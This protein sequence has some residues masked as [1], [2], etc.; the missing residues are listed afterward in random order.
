MLRK[1]A[2]RTASALIAGSLAL[3]LAFSTATLAEDQPGK[4]DF[5]KQ[6]MT[7]LG[8][9]PIDLGRSSKK[10]IGAV[11]AT[12]AAE[13][14]TTRA[15]T[16]RSGT[17]SMTRFAAISTRR[18]LK[19]EAAAQPA[20]R[21]SG[22]LADKAARDAAEQPAVRSAEMTLDRSAP[23]GPANAEMDRSAKPLLRA[24]IPDAGSREALAM[25]A[26]P[27]TQSVRSAQAPNE[28]LSVRMTRGTWLDW[29]FGR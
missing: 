22:S 4:R 20:T 21:S 23:R 11:A 5:K 28:H 15:S 3:G 10:E 26:T 14:P 24:A 12:R 7:R 8:A 25:R 27:E 29:F 19:P 2:L 6:S 9:A 17:E 18:E 1:D 13:A 16:A